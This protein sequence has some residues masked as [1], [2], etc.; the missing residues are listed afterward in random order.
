MNNNQYGTVEQC[1]NNKKTGTHQKKRKNDTLTLKW[2][3]KWNKGKNDKIRLRRDQ[4][5]WIYNTIKKKE[6]N[7]DDHWSKL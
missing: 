2:Q 4:E 7:N 1:K 6:L 3:K 5:R